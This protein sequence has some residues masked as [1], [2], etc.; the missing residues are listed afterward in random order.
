VQKLMGHKDVETTM[1]YVHV[2][3]KLGETV[4]SPADTFG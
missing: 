3:Q 2:T 1:G 4:R